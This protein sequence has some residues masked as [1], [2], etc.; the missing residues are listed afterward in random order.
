MLEEEEWGIFTDGSVYD[1][2][3]PIAIAG[4]AVCQ[5]VATTGKWKRIRWPV[6][7]YLPQTA[8]LAEM[9]GLI[10]ALGATRPGSKC[11]VAKLWSM[12]LV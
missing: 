7:L 9:V 8:T 2:Y 12:G 5:N 6:P 4:C 3:L 1:M 10:I 11:R